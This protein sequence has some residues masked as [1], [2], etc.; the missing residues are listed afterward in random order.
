VRENDTIS[1]ELPNFFC[2]WMAI[3]NVVVNADLSIDN[4]DLK[5]RTFTGYY[6]ITFHGTGNASGSGYY[7]AAILSKG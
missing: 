6:K 1:V 3:G 7:R 2:N 5:T 4:I